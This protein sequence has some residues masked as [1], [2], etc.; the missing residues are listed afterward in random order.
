MKEMPWVHWTV[1]S[2]ATGDNVIETW[3]CFARSLS[4]HKRNDGTLL[5]NDNEKA[6]EYTYDPQKG[7][8]YV[9]HVQ[10][11]NRESDLLPADTFQFVQMTMSRI[12]K[13]P[14]KV[15]RQT[16]KE[17]GRQVE[18]ITAQMARNSATKRIVL[19]RDVERNLLLRMKVDFGNKNANRLALFDYPDKGPENIYQ[20]GAPQ[21][22]KIV[23]LVVP[24]DIP[25]LIKKL[26]SLR[27]SCLSRYVGLSLP[28]DTAGVA[29]SFTANRPERYF[30]SKDTLPCFIWRYCE[31][32]RVSRGYF[33]G[34]AKGMTNAELLS[35]DL[36]DLSSLL[37]PVKSSIYRNGRVHL[38]QVLGTGSVRWTER[39]PVEVCG[40]DVF[41]EQICWPEIVVPQHGDVKWRIESVTESD[42][43]PLIMIE[44]A[45]ESGMKERWFINPAM[46]CI[47]EKHEVF[48]GSSLM[49][50][51]VILDY[52]R[53]TTGQWYPRLIER[54]EYGRRKTDAGEEPATTRR[55]ISVQENP[56]FD[57]GIFDP[58]S[59]PEASK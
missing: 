58:E 3:F 42:K 28:A 26:N 41:V 36:Q 50:V 44:R 1:R 40:R 7:V 31:K 32:R 11:K 46:S 17:N 57:E 47:C 22:A 59:L 27:Q 25:P 52:A 6:T 10:A 39:K 8:I 24:S 49:E 33:T 48:N 4:A 55:T 19:T 51:M 43:G 34:E 29:T 21:D 30:T 38:W 23:T 35:K 15:A 45:M 5:Y 14:S 53:T 54:T 18:I 20:L 9:S 16:T 37:V 2:E 13:D 12:A 56:D